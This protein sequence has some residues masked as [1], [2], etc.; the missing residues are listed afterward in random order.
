MGHYDRLMR[1]ALK[2]IAKKRYTGH[3]LEKKLTKK[4][5]EAS[6]QRKK[7]MSRLKELGYIDDAAFARDYISTRLRLNP[8][9][10]R[11]LAVELLRK[12][13][14][15]QTIDYALDNADIDEVS[16][17]KRIL[18]KRKHRFTS[19]TYYKK[20]AKMMRFLSSRGFSSDAIYKVL[21]R[22]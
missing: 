15:K 1:Y 10:R 14:A 18:E 6:E 11:L 8:R 4:D 17:A 9:G 3:E 19:L 16:L 5:N 7:V 12:G 2:L 13:V 21:E 22:C 20:R